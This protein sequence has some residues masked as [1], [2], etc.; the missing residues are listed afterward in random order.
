MAEEAQ[1]VSLRHRVVV[2]LLCI[3]AGIAAAVVYGIVHDMVTAHVCVE[4][5]TEYHP[6][7]VDS[8]NPVVLAL[9]WGVVA[10]WWVGAPLGLLLSAGVAAGERPPLPWPRV[11]RLLAWFVGILLLVSL[12]C[13]LVGAS[14]AWPAY[15]LPKDL[16]PERATRF[17]FVQV[18]HLVSYGAGVLGGL[19]LPAI[20]WHWRRRSGNSAE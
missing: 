20:A 10:T 17:Q 13:G 11:F 14:S 1:D 2:A 15:L 6:R 18:S 3:P 12:G 9:F 16:P 8:G 19:V 4:Y 5:F 7:L